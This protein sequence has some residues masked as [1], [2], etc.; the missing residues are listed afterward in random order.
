MLKHDRQKYILSRLE[1]TGSILIN[2]IID[3]LDCS[4]ETLRR[5]LIDMENAGKLTRT[6]GGAY[7]PDKFNKGVPISL[8]KTMLV[9]EKTQIAEKAFQL[10]KE[11]SV[12]FL[13]HSSTCAQLAKKIAISHKAIT[14]ITNSIIS[15]VILSAS[16]NPSVKLISTGGTYHSKNDAYTGKITLDTI[17]RFY[18]SISFISP[19][20]VS[21]KVG[22]TD[23]SLVSACIREEMIKQS[24]KVVIL[25]D[26]TKIGHNADVKIS[27]L[28]SVDVL[29]T[30]K[31]LPSK[32]ESKLQKNG[33]EVIY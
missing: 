25:M 33:I 22:L 13:D 28:K 16:N 7:L 5:D 3:D 20:F 6:Y 2:D 1:L 18:A 29:I 15:S 11:H 24:E 32:T 21:S 31:K 9:K 4:F 23:N 8:R 30:D 26:H 17:N 19:P 27:N 10:I 12:I 14:V